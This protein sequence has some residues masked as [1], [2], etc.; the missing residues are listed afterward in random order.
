MKI[1]S[2]VDESKIC[3]C[4]KNENCL[5]NRKRGRLDGSSDRSSEPCDALT[6]APP[7]QSVPSKHQQ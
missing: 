1:A 2:F 5:A 4:P 7:Y 3:I 6:A